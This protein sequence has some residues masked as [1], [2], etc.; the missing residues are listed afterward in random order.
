LIYADEDQAK[1]ERLVK[2]TGQM[3]VPITEVLYEDQE[4]EFILGF[5]RAKLGELLIEA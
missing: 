3:G 5:D 4:S 1:A 2:R